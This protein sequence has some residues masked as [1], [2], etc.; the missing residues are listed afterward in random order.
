[1]LLLTSTNATMEQKL[2]MAATFRAGALCSLGYALLSGK[3]EDMDGAKAAFQELASIPGKI[4]N[5]LDCRERINGNLQV[6]RKR[7]D[8]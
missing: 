7:L 3:S 6:Q 4:L 2:G 5:S 8:G 1:M